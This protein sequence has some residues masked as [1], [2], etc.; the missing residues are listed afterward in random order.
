MLISARG[1]RVKQ[2]SGGRDARRPIVLQKSLLEFG[3]VRK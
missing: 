3:S 1:L 2:V